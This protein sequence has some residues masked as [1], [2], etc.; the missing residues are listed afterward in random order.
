MSGK[1]V[2]PVV[3]L[4]VSLFGRF[5]EAD[6]PHPNFLKAESFAQL[7]EE[8]ISLPKATYRLWAWARA[9]VPFSIKVGAKELTSEKADDA[10]KDE[11]FAWR[12]MGE[13]T[14]AKGT[15]KIESEKPDAVA[16]LCLS[17]NDHFDPGRLWSCMWT[18][19]DDPA[20]VADARAG[21]CRHINKTYETWSYASKEEWL[22]RAAHLKRHILV[23]CGLYPRPE[24]T[25]LKPKR[26]GRIDRDTYSVEKVYFESWPGFYVTGNLYLPRSGKGPSP[27]VLCPHGHWGQGR[28]TY[29]GE[30]RGG[31]P[32]RA[33]TLAK[34]GCVVFTY[35][36][37]GFG[38]S[39]KQMGH[40][41]AGNDNELWGTNLM[42]LQL[43]NSIRSID[44]LKSLSFV[45]PERIA[46][47]GASGGG[48]Q[49]FIL[50]AVDGRIKV[51]A[52]VNMVSAFMQGGCE[53]ENAPLLRLDTIN[54]EIAGLMAPRPLLM[55]SATGDWTS[56]TPEVEYPMV[57][58]IY[59]H[60]GAEDRVK[61][62]HVDGPHNYNRASREAMYNFFL[63]WFL[64]ENREK[65]YTEP[66]FT[67]EKRDDLSVWAGRS[68]P[69]GALDRKG[70][71]AFLKKETQQTL[72]A[73]FPGNKARLEKFREVYGSVYCHALYLEGRTEGGS[74]TGE[75]LGA[76]SV[77]LPWC[78]DPVA[79]VQLVLRKDDQ[80][81][82]AVLFLPPS[83]KNAGMKRAC[84]LIHPEGKAA[85]FLDAF[86]GDGESAAG[87]FTEQNAL[88][89]LLKQ[90][91]SVLTMDPFL[92]GE[93][94]SAFRTTKRKR[95]GRMFTTYNRTILVERVRDIVLAAAFLEKMVK[96]DVL[97]AGVGEA[98][99]WV[100]LAAPFLSG[101]VQVL[102]DLNGYV[103]GS[104]AMWQGENF[105]PSVLAFG[106]L[107][108]AAALAAPRRLT[109]FNTGEL[110]ERKW[111]DA[112]YRAAG[113]PK[114]LK[115]LAGDSASRLF[116]PEK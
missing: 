29:E 90:G 17:R 12:L 13:V 60:F 56:H 8:G 2:L 105:A 86:S 31:V 54:P 80:A 16:C 52:P 3:F 46:C 39:K 58:S 97:V 47:T 28:F 99:R 112:A 113:S 43:W 83:Q 114:R 11:G 98:G 92:C 75:T 115:I 4:Y 34:L 9:D 19:A 33:I 18:R 84:L 74:I 78:K 14:F 79:T 72:N 35:D 5:V 93:F 69:D 53:C 1:S 109:L 116:E 85:A 87:P 103:S 82:P 27:A 36:M 104:E 71:E 63:N 6:E 89:L 76:R 68:L 37:V 70:L 32:P 67:I 30:P 23:S 81:V 50:M 26:F 45:D 10:A 111:P 55:V 88:A 48:T 94:H 65:P 102:A 49:T 64:K 110:F 95:E 51:A 15:I 41:I 91:R 108:T 44:F 73:Y 7:A 96:Q 106:A 42:K 107:K 57:R 40:S 38:D 25:P 101:D 21:T 24:K 62:V 22:E 20:A 100:M 66:P 77:K 61:N 59:K